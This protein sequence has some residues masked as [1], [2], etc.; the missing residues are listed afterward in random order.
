M[1]CRNHAEYESA[2]RGDNEEEEKQTNFPNRGDDKKIS[3][4][5][6]EYP[7]FDRD[8]AKTI[9]EEHPDIWRAGG[10]IEGNRSYRLLTDHLNNDKETPTI[11][12]KIKERESWSARHFEDGSQFK[13]P[14]TMPNLSNIGGVIAQ[15]KWLTIGTLG[16]RGMKD[17]VMEVIK[18]REDKAY[19]D[20]EEEEETKAP[21]LTA[22]ARKG[23][24]NKV[25][26]SQ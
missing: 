23:I 13:D 26:R 9:K 20:D 24:E 25:K 16:E 2:L 4:R 18:K 11:L 8:F 22:K 14:D 12:A 6:S 1:P 10:N 3:L 7:L 17:V 5:N 19:H 15:M 21:R